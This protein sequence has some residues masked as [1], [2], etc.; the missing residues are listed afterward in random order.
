MTYTSGFV[1]EFKQHLQAFEE[2]FRREKE[3]GGEDFQAR[4]M[5]KAQMLHSKINADVMRM[6]ARSTEVVDAAVREADHASAARRGRLRG[7][8]GPGQMRG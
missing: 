2:D 4:I 5:V 3:I 8:G 6:V 1:S 7:P